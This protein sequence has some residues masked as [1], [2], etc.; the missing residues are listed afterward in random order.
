M[1]V[2]R[3]YKSFHLKFQFISFYILKNN[4]NV[5]LCCSIITPQ[6]FL[7]YKNQIKEIFPSEDPDIY[8]RPSI[9]KNQSGIKGKCSPTGGRLYERYKNVLKRYREVGQCSKENT[10]RLVNT[11]SSKCTSNFIVVL[12]IVFESQFIHL[13]FCIDKCY[14]IILGDIKKSLRWLKH[15]KE[16]RDEVILHWKRTS[17]ARYEELIREGKGTIHEYMIKFSLMTCSLGHTLINI[18]FM[19]LYGDKETNIYTEWPLFFKRFFATAS[20]RNLEKAKDLMTLSTEQLS[21]CKYIVLFLFHL[22]YNFIMLS[23]KSVYSFYIQRE[24]PIS[25][26]L[27]FFLFYLFFCIKLFSLSLSRYIILIP[28]SIQI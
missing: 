18:D 26:K 7:D 25:E 4:S 17:K 21:D 27:I 2:K 15:N 10:S 24:L 23:Y 6:D 28:V 16:P 19:R 8:Y 12:I 11:D 5:Y 9:Y 14:F 22:N 20:K 13:Y 3:K 1:T